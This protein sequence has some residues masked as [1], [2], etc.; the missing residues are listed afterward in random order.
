M[1]TDGQAYGSPRSAST[2]VGVAAMRSSQRSLSSTRAS[3]FPRVW[4]DCLPSMGPRCERAARDA[5]FFSPRRGSV[6]LFALLHH[7]FNRRQQVGVSDRQPALAIEVA[8][9]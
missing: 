5:P 9:T 3:S 6:P 1:L 4:L 8:P 7:A 2:V